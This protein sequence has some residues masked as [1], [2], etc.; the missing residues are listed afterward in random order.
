MEN[1]FIKEIALDLRGTESGIR[2]HGKFKVKTLLTRR[3]R[4]Q[5]DEHRRRLVGGYNPEGALVTLQEEA[6]ILGQ[7]RVRVVDAPQW[8]IA[9]GW[10]EDLE[11]GNVIAKLFDEA[12]LA[13][14]QR[15]DGLV[16]S[17]EQA[18]EGMAKAKQE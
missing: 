14:K 9:A 2:R 4:F 1:E 5:A 17:A 6:Y 16:A 15:V 11:D 8:W 3:D 13:E 7:L 10:G 18:H 12:K